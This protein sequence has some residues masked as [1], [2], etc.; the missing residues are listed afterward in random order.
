MDE[1]A[2]LRLAP[3]DRLA[4]GVVVGVA[5]QHDVYI[6]LAEH[7]YLVYL[8]FRRRFR[9]KNGPLDV[10]LV[11]GEGDPLRV[12]AR[13]GADDAARELLLRKPGYLVIGAAYLIR[14]DD[15]HILA[16]E[17]DIGSIPFG[18]LDVQHKRRIYHYAAYALLCF[19]NIVKLRPVV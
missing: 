18:Q 14:T 10:K 3:G 6:I 16:L 7:L 8:L 13:R 5:R 17:P 4:A 19:L 2:V 1:G 11:A 15:L 9:H 12:V